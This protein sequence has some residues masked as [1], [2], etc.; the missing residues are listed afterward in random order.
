MVNLP[1]FEG[2]LFDVWLMLETS[3]LFFIFLLGWKGRGGYFDLNQLVWFQIFLLLKKPFIL[4]KFNQV[5]IWDKIILRRDNGLL[6]Y[7]GM[8]T[9]YYFFDDGMGLKY[10]E[11]IFVAN[12]LIWQQNYFY[13]GYNVI[14]FEIVILDRVVCLE[15]WLM[16]FTCQNCF[17]LF[18]LSLGMHCFFQFFSMNLYQFLGQT[19]FFWLCAFW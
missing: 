6:N 11:L 3:S 5:V 13:F 4:Q 18:S 15:I 10:G 9:K 8:N 2:V 17:F 19:F 14:S 12:E 7:N 16:Q 1:T